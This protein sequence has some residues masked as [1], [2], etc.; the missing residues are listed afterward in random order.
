[1]EKIKTAI[2]R[3]TQ[4]ETSRKQSAAK[5]L[6]T[7]IL[8]ERASE[9]GATAARQEVIEVLKDLDGIPNWI[10]QRLNTRSFY[11]EGDRVMGWW[12]KASQVQAEALPLY[13]TGRS[14]SV[15]FFGRSNEIWLWN[16]RGFYTAEN[17]P[18]MFYATPGSMQVEFP[19]ERS[20]LFLEY[21]YA[22]PCPLQWW[23]RQ[24]EE[25]RV[26]RSIISHGFWQAWKWWDGAQYWYWER[27]PEL[28]ADMDWWEPEQK[29]AIHPKPNEFAAVLG[30][31]Q[32]LSRI[33]GIIR[34]LE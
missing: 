33:E 10:A 1:M 26:S 27:R 16:Q 12:D 30:S 8:N 7:R 32:A 34:Y 31:N 29:A 20:L 17:L 13:S 14:Y 18:L 24:G 25:L 11:K 4:A 28:F 23:W 21:G 19:V 6:I 9:V 15:S 2:E 22:L 3:Y 5:G